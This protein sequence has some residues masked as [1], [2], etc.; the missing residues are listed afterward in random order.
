M[1]FNAAHDVRSN[2][3]SFSESGHFRE[4]FN[5]YCDTLDIFVFEFCSMSV[6]SS[7]RIASTYEYMYDSEAD[8]VYN[9]AVSYRASVPVFPP[10][11]QGR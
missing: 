1:A 2:S 7:D 10:N 4:F 11:G 8:L 5:P 9:L 6:I 3:L